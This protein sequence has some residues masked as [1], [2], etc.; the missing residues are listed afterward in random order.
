M[1]SGVDENVPELNQ[2]MKMGTCVTR[3]RSPTLNLHDFKVL[4]IYEFNVAKLLS[5]FPTVALP[6]I[7]LRASLNYASLLHLVP[8]LSRLASFAISF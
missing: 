2:I 7:L 3:T 6:N 5:I 8:S 4:R 1:R